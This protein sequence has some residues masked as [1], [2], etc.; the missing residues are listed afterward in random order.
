MSGQGISYSAPLLVLATGIASHLFYFHVGEHHMLGVIYIQLFI[1][2]C[3]VSTLCLINFTET[4]TAAAIAKVFEL[5]GFWLAGVYGS[6]VTYRLFF[7]PLNKF[8]GPW[9]AR[10]SDLWLASKMGRMQGYHIIHNMHKQYGEFVRV[11]SNTLSI[12]DSQ[13]MQPAYGSHANV[14]KADWYDGA[15]P[16][17]SMHTT[18]DR[19]LH[20]RRRRVW[21][22]AFSDKALREYENTVQELNN[23]FVNRIEGFEGQTTNVTT[24]FNLY[25]FDVMGRLAFGKDYGMIEAGR[26]RSSIHLVVTY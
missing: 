12:T 3:V 7:H 8:P 22:P 2:A 18:R 5:A 9:Q 19:G 1:L 23:K 20:D 21:A 14:I 4:A 13:M 26:S 25:S 10:L 15:A 11:G 24:W 16:H 6:L 17:H